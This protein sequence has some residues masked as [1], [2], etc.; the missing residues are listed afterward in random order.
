MLTF[1][2]IYGAEV[3][4]VFSA[5][6]DMSKFV[7][8]EVLSVLSAYYVMLKDQISVLIIAGIVLYNCTKCAICFPYLFYTFGPPAQ[9]H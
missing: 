8:A 1:L 2:H 3:F 6:S 7:N 5:S 4:N 9:Q